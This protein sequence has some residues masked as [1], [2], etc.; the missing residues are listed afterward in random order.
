M[1]LIPSLRRQMNLC[2]LKAS[3]ANGVRSRPA[4]GTLSHK[5]GVFGGE[6]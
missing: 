3:L 6:S 5:K 4:R 2:G 1:S